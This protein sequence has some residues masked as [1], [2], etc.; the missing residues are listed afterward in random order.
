MNAADHVHRDLGTPAPGSD[1]AA[2]GP[3]HLT[4]DG[5]AVEAPAGTT[6][7]R[8]ALAAGI[9]IPKLCATDSLAPFGSCRVCLVEIQ[10]RKGTPASCTTPVEAGMVV[11]TQTETL[12]RVR[13]GVLELYISDHPLDCLTCAANG[14][15]ELQDVAGEV[16][17]RDVRYGFAGANHLGQHRGSH[18]LRHEV[19][20]ARLQAEAPFFRE[21]PAGQANEPHVPVGMVGAQKAN[22]LSAA[23]S[24]HFQVDECEVRVECRGIA[25]RLRTVVCDG[26]DAVQGLK[27]RTERIGAVDVVVDNEDAELRAFSPLIHRIPR[28]G[29]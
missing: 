27:K 10:G 20:E 16:G 3:V 7:L 28:N 14:D 11:R 25:E 8:A 26:R 5:V 13:K 18:R 21:V 22:D 24:G 17:L 29:Q 4:I 15:C 1:A 23:H 12:A 2:S 6:V 9:G 19:M